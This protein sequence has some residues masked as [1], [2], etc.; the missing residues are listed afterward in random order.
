M[1]GVAPSPLTE[2]AE[3]VRG[4]TFSKGDAVAEP[5]EGYTPVLRAGN[6]QSHLILDSDLVYIPEGMVSEKQRLRGGDIVMCTSSGSAEI[7]GKTAFA[8]QDWI[9]SFG[10]FCAVVRPKLGKC[11]PRYLFHYLQTPRF[12]DWTRN[13]SGVGIKN[14]RKSELDSYEVPFPSLD[15]QRR[16][17]VTL[18]KA[19]AIRRKREQVLVLADEFLKSVFLEMFGRPKQPSPAL[20]TRP[21][22]EICDLFA[23]NSL[24]AGEPYSEQDGGYLLLKVGDLNLP[25]NEQ[26]VMSAR[27]WLSEKTKAGAAIVA[28]KNAIVFPKRGG[29]IATNKKRVLGRSCILD[30]NLMAVAPKTHSPVSWPYLRVWF[31]MLDLASISNGSTVP[32]LNK[33]D[34]YP[35]EMAIPDKESLASFDRIFHGVNTAHVRLSSDLLS[36][37][38]LFSSLSQRAFCGEL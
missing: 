7:V 12:R 38:A 13:S 19:D 24:P 23:G 28:P 37:E 22:A 8:D 1:S 15:E 25:G 2:K 31:E 34:L 33:G 17:A 35:L 30:P 21:L 16:I 10:A 18:D 29:A 3:V 11:D 36:S 9:G 20:K 27:E 4:V 14:I 5:R 6:I 32:Q 26:T